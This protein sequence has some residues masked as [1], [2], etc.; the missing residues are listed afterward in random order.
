MKTLFVFAMLMAFSAAIVGCEA[1]GS[2]GDNSGPEHKTV[3]EKTVTDSNGN[4]ISH[5]E[6]KHT[7][8]NNP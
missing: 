3:K 5:S 8:T 6:E 7:D 4:V 2:V 1:S